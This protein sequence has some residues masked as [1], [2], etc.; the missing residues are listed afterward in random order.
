MDSSL[1]HYKVQFINGDAFV[2]G[3]RVTGCSADEVFTKA[4][5]L[6]VEYCNITHRNPDMFHLQF[7]MEIPR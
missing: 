4:V 7:I 6:L 1:R 2:F 5:D 3:T